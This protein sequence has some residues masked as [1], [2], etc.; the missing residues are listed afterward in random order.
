MAQQLRILIRALW[1]R[2]A[3][4]EAGTPERRRVADANPQMAAQMQMAAQ[5]K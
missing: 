4:E 2:I 1:Q 3:D 5:I